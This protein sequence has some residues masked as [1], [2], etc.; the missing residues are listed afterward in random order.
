MFRKKEPSKI[1][2]S[3]SA[4]KIIWKLPN[5]LIHREDGPAKIYPSGSEEWWLNGQL[6]RDN[7][8]AIIGNGYVQ[9][10]IKGKKCSQ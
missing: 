5:G 7:G 1:V 8:P 6:H 10:W 4:Y 3:S 9:Y 2:S